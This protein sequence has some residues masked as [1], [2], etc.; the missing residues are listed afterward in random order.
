M[1]YKIYPPDKEKI[2]KYVKK[3][4]A[5]GSFSLTDF[6]WWIVLNAKYHENK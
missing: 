3:K 5:E 4:E 2:R 1:K 6:A